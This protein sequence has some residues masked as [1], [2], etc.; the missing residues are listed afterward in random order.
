MENRRLE[1]EAAVRRSK[2]PADGSRGH[3]VA[4]ERS[5]EL[6]SISPVF[7]K[8]LRHQ[9][10][11]SPSQW[12]DFSRRLSSELEASRTPFWRTTRDKLAATDNHLVHWVW[13]I[14]ALVLLIL[15]AVF[16]AL[17][18]SEPAISVAIVNTA[19]ALTATG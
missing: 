13:I 12:R 11:P 16:V 3:K 19:A 10:D 17:S 7:R 4:F 8:L 2:L 1:Q 5:E 6:R 14:I 15:T 9:A 18:A